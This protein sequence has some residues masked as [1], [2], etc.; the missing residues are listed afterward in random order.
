LDRDPSTT[1]ARDSAG[2]VLRVTRRGA[3][4][5]ETANAR[6]RI[7]PAELPEADQPPAETG[8]EERGPGEAA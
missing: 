8:E 5:L 1:A 6:R 7:P 2:V 4:V 3:L